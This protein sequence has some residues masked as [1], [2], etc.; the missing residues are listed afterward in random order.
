MFRSILVAATVAAFVSSPAL[1]QDYEGLWT[2]QGE[3]E[4]ELH[5]SHLDGD[6]YKLSLSTVV[7]IS[8]LGGGCAGGVSGEVAL[9]A[10]GGTFSTENEGYDPEE[11]TSGFNQRYCEVTL[12]FND[13]GSL[14][15]EEQQGCLYYH[16]AACGFSGTVAHDAAG[17]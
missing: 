7:P 14:V 5:L 16:G 17:L 15:L 2:G 4:L 10:E 12:R 1:A 13:D 9:T 3:G 8:D 11:E 6:V